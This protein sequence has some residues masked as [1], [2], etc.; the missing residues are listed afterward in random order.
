[1]YVFILFFPLVLCGEVL[2]KAE[3]KEPFFFSVSFSS[4]NLILG[5][6]LQ[7]KIES[8][9]PANYQIKS[10]EIIEDLLW[11]ANP[12]S[13]FWELRDSSIDQTNSQTTIHLSVIPLVEGKLP[14]ALSKM[15]F[16]SN[17]NEKNLSVSTPLFYF[18]ISLPIHIKIPQFAPLIPLEPE[19]PLFVSIENETKWMNGPEA[20]EQSEKEMKKELY[21]HTFPWSYVLTLLFIAAM[22][23]LLKF[24]KHIGLFK[25]QQLPLQT[26]AIKAIENELMSLKPI[27]NSPLNYPAL[28]MLFKKA[29]QDHF[30]LNTQTLT[31]SEIA[32]LLK[33]QTPLTQDKIEDAVTLMNAMDQAKY[34]GRKFS[35][36]EEVKLF[37]KLHAFVAHTSLPSE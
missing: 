35:G 30:K 20:L 13:P 24:F 16:Y 36:Q 14:L 2:W 1:M 32:A 12:L 34:A 15:T 21:A 6:T 10:Y 19:F 33:T 8:L 29:I 25:S 37:E 23:C 28:S 27:K 18:D 7:V 9:F 11:S 3:L 22:V 31:S 4:E 26:N 5:Q 17:E